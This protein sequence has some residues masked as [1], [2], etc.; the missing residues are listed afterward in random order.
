MESNKDKVKKSVEEKLKEEYLYK[1][2]QSEMFRK[3]D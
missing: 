1:Q 3:Q 2:I